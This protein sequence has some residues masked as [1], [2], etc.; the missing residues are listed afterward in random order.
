MVDNYNR[1]ILEDLIITESASRVPATKK[2]LGRMLLQLLEESTF[3]EIS[4]QVDK[5][6]E[7][8]KEWY[9]EVM[10]AFKINFDDEQR[11]W[12][13]VFVRGEDDCWEF[14][15]GTMDNSGRGRFHLGGRKIM[16]QRIAYA[17]E[18][19]FMPH[20]GIRRICKNHNCVNPKH[21]CMVGEQ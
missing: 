9:M 4:K 2:E 13:Q 20:L 16:A 8:L 7:T 11:F 6:I 15:G 1:I 21:L 12:S 3:N 5:D 14:T 18:H 19:G 10:P 17:I